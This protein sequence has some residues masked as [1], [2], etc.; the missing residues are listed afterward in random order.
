M[1]F[2]DVMLADGAIRRTKDGYAAISAKVARAGNVQIYTGAELG[3]QDRATVRLF[4]PEGS[5]F[6]RHA[7]AS[8]AGVPITMGHPKGGV[9]ADSWKQHAVGEVG[10][11]VLRDGEFIRVPMMLRDAAAIAAVEGGTR[12]LSMGYDAQIILQ[13]GMSPAGEPY[14]AIMGPVTMN[15]VAI[16][17]MA[18]GGKELRIGDGAEKWGAAPIT[19]SNKEDKMSDALKTVVLG[20]QAVQVAATDHAAIEAW[21]ASTAKQISDMQTSHA[22]ALAVKDADLAKA[23]AA[24]DAAEAKVL[25]AAAIDKLVADRGDLVAKAKAIA[26]TVAATGLSDAALRKAVVVAKLGDAM[27]DK[28][29]AYI[30]ARFDILAEDAKP[31]DPVQKALMDAK[32]IT[33]DTLDQVYADQRK[34]LADAWKQPI[35]QEA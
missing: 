27:K 11:E 19:T 10:D 8:Y 35:N 5:V 2:T 34:S 22:A 9:S 33:P 25:D 23:N 20:D 6:D 24:K 15:H 31:V 29:D 3:M 4:R 28:P 16:V 26:P 13:D 18:R 12:E 30:D 17:P 1:K 21:K 14:D 7:V 32:P